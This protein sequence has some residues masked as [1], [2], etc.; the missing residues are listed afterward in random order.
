MATNEVMSVSEE[1]MHAACERGWINDWVKELGGKSFKAVANGLIDVEHL[2]VPLEACLSELSQIYT[3]SHY[4]LDH[5][6]AG[7]YKCTDMD[8]TLALA[9]LLAGACQRLN[10]TERYTMTQSGQRVCVMAYPHITTG[11]VY[12]FFSTAEQLEEILYKDVWGPNPR[13]PLGLHD[14]GIEG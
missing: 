7:D 1:I 3:G 9:L 8:R 5:I 10:F 2:V 14:F 12:I 11:E 4:G 6:R 13:L